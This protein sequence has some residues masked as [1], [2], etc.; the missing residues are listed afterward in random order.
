MGGV[1]ERARSIGPAVRGGGAKNGRRRSPSCACRGSRDRHDLDGGDAE[2]DE[3]IEPLAAAAKVPSARERAD[4][5]LV[6][7]LRSARGADGARVAQANARG[8]MILRRAV[9]AVGLKARRGLG[10]APPPS[11]TS[12]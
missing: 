9:H 12:W 4:V 11:M 1:D 8:S 5:E 2:I 7:D 3:P 10:R 6:D